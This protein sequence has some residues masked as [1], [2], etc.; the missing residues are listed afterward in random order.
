MISYLQSVPSELFC[1]ESPAK[2]YVSACLCA[3]PVITIV[4]SYFYVKRMT[5]PIPNDMEIK[6]LKKLLE[7]QDLVIDE[8]NKAMKNQ[9]ET[10][11][12]MQ[13][14]MCLS[15]VAFHVLRKSH[16]QAGGKE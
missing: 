3:L 16:E 8:Q 14:A 1:S 9:E 10:L 4:G 6:K 11:L 5:R 7:A 2:Y 15:R 12:L 13:N